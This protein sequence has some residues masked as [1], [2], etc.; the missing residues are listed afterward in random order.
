M[1]LIPIILFLVCDT[2]LKATTYSEKYK[3]E[4]P[5]ERMVYDALEARGEYVR[6]QVPC[7]RYSIDI[8]L[9]VYHL[10][11]ECDGAALS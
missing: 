5:I 9:P 3:C 11:I 10:A 4:S 7:G 8:A 1:V 6:T 2:R